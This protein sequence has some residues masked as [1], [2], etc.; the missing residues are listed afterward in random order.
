MIEMSMA[1]PPEPFC[2]TDGG[3]EW[4]TGG[5]GATVTGK[6]IRLFIDY[7]KENSNGK[8]KIFEYIDSDTEEHFL[9]LTQFSFWHKFEE[10]YE[11]SETEGDGECWED[12][13]K[14]WKSFEKTILCEEY[15]EKFDNDD[16]FEEWYQRVGREFQGDI[17]L[18]TGLEVLRTFGAEYQDMTFLR[19]MPL[20]R[21]LEVVESRFVSLTGIDDL[22]RLK[23]LCCWLD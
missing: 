21:V 20:L 8:D 11:E 23:Q 15:T 7:V 18:F 1:V 17:S 3:D 12:M 14:K 19:T 10:K 9:Q 2:D 16:A 13:V 22:V 6:F 5:N 4:K